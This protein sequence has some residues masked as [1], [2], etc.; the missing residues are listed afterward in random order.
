LRW[1]LNTDDPKIF[2]VDNASVSGMDFSSLPSDVWMV[3]WTDGRGELETQ[4]DPLTNDNGL[5]EIFIDVVPY[6]PLF[7]QFLAM[8]P[9]LTLGQAQ[10]VQTDLIKQIFESKRQDP[11]HYPV[12]AGD[13]SWDASDEAL[14]SSYGAQ[15]QISIAAVNQQLNQQLNAII[16]ALIGND[17]SL[18]TFINNKIVGPGTDTLNS[19]LRGTLNTGTGFYDVHPGILNDIAHVTI[20]T[21]TWT[22]MPGP[23]TGLQWIPIG[24]TTPV[25]VTPA[26]E[27][28]ILSGIAARTNTLAGKKNT[29]VA[30]VKA[31]TA[32]PDVIDY[33]VTTGWSGAAYQFVGE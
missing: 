17:T 22:P 2:A 7:Q 4:V 19:S 16:P 33:D 12:A 31:L 3:H 14:F 13:F 24:G 26:E 20:S 15:L 25:P 1:W 6:A 9:R 27:T 29:K 11:F 5:R 8:L 28:A 30:E 23:T 10:R 32:I 18:A 21:P